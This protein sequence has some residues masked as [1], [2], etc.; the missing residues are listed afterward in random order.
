M[1]FTHNN[2]IRSFGNGSNW[3]I[4]MRPPTRPVKSYYEETVLAAEMI[5]SQK[6]GK[7]YVTY[8]GG[9]DSEYTLS[10]FLSLGMNITPVIL[11]TQYNRHETK[12]AFAFCKNKNIIPVIV[13]LDYDKFV[14]SGEFLKI[15]ESVESAAYQVAANA[16]LTSQVDGTIIT[17]DAE[18]HLWLNDDQKWYLDEREPLHS[19]FKYFTK[20]NV[21]GTPWFLSYTPE[22]F[23]AFLIDPTMR[24]LANNEI[25]GKKGTHSSKVHVYNN[26]TVFQLEQRVKQSGYE[27]FEISPIFNHPDVRTVDSWKNKWWGNVNLEYT[28]L[29]Q[30]LLSGETVYGTTE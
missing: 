16:W 4:E 3:G 9:L 20:Y 30:K 10:V 6:Q 27:I 21:C 19:L 5:W 12:Y 25:Y 1:E 28:E 8:S 11:N 23:L 22:Q 7:L 15:S 2:Y 26:Q 14:E 17:G 13:D 18:P 24:S 29:V